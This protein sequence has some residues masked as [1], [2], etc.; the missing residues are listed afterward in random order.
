VTIGQ[1]ENRVGE[2]RGKTAAVQVNAS[3]VWYLRKTRCPTS[4]PASKAQNGQEAAITAPASV[5][6]QKRAPQTAERELAERGEDGRP[7]LKT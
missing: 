4:M 5:E 6:D 7:F 1:R 2:E 3:R